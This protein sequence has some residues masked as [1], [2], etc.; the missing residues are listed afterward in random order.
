[1]KVRKQLRHAFEWWVVM[2]P[3]LAFTPDSRQTAAGRLDAKP[4]AAPAATATADADAD[5]DPRD[6]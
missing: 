1:M 4:A 3:G 5:A 2:P 6:P